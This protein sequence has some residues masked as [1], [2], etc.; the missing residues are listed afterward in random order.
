MRVTHN[1]TFDNWVIGLIYQVEQRPAKKRSRFFYIFIVT[2][3]MLFFLLLLI[4]DARALSWVCT[5]LFL[6]VA[7]ALQFHSKRSWRKRY[8]RQLHSQLAP[9][10]NM[11]KDNQVNWTVTPECISM[12]ERTLE[13][14]I[15]WEGVRK[16][17]IC[18]RLLFFDLMDYSVG[19]C[20]PKA[21]INETEY[22]AFR[23]EA[24][25]LYREHAAKEGK[26]AQVIHS[27]WTIDLQKLKKRNIKDIR[28]P[29]AAWRW[30]AIAAAGICFL[31]T[32]PMIIGSF[33]DAGLAPEIV[34]RRID[35][36]AWRD[37]SLESIDLPIHTSLV[38]AALLGPVIAATWAAFK[39]GYSRSYVPV[40]II[41]AYLTGTILFVPQALLH[42][43]FYEPSTPYFVKNLLI[44]LT[45]SALLL[46]VLLVFRKTKRRD[47][48]W[49]L[50]GSFVWMTA[51]FYLM[52]AFFYI[53][54]PFYAIE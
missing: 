1:A 46:A 45:V 26:I 49:A 30:L 11:Q 35:Y 48:T 43:H 10:F 50:A 32:L 38:L 19:A 22:Q 27:D 3:A 16:I 31:L 28:L 36:C 9:S 40:F 15:Q 52:A 6:T 8:Y 53:F 39:I 44:G 41:A 42:A 17:V 25:R 2:V 29:K 34:A 21:D 24:I 47:L 33:S 18:P 23:E 14:R 4:T 37:T 20:L 5:S 12:V 54:N 7:I 51:A 13:T